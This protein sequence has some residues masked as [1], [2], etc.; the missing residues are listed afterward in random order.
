MPENQTAWN[1]DNHRIKETVKENNQTSKVAN[2]EKARGGSDRGG[3]AGCRVAA[4][5]AGGAHLRETEIQRW[6]WTST[7][8]PVGETP[9]L[10]LV[11]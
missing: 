9:S 7:V 4:G 11:R 8:A 5:Y 6:L 3:G 10:T 1:S 2:G